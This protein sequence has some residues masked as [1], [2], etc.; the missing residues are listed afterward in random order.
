M[1]LPFVGVRSWGRID[2]F[3]PKMESQLLPWPLGKQSWEISHVVVPN[4]GQLMKHLGVASCFS[5]SQSSYP[6][7]HSH[8]WRSQAEATLRQLTLLSP[9]LTADGFF[10]LCN[11]V[12]VMAAKHVP[13]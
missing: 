6:G 8:S 1:D 10:P 7:T 4:G 11:W 5:L 13:Q 12:R 9:G 3:P 2:L